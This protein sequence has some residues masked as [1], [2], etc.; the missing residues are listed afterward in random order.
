VE[1]EDFIT[2]QDRRVWEL[3]C[4]SW[5]G[6]DRVKSGIPAEIDGQSANR[7]AEFIDGNLPESERDAFER[8]LAEDSLL[9]DGLLA[10]RAGRDGPVMVSEPPESLKAWALSACATSDAANTSSPSSAP[11]PKRPSLKWRISSL[12]RQPIFT[13]GLATALV[14]IVGGTS[15]LLSFDNAPKVPTVAASKVDSGSDDWDSNSIFADPKKAY[16]DGLD[17][18]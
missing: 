18:E 2:K 5:D 13:A 7:I 3:Y 15:L 8:A 12:L 14:L 6:D 16:F 11:K 9:L 10:A 17:I 4:R 1:R